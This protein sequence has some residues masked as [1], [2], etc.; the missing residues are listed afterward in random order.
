MSIFK[1]MILKETLHLL[2]DFRTL[3]V[4]LIM[5]LVLLLLF[6]F[7]IS[8]EVNDVRIVAVVGQ[9]NNHTR[10][11][12]ERLRTNPYFTFCGIVPYNQVEPAL[13]K[14]NADAAIIMTCRNGVNASQIIVDGSNTNIAQTATVYIESVL[15]GNYKSP[16]LTRTIYNPQLKSAY[17]FVPG[18]MGMIFILICA[19]MTSV[20]I[21]S[22]KESG[23]MNLLLVSPVRPR[24]IILGKMVPYFL[25]SCII[26]ALMLLLSYTVL[27]IPVSAA[28]VNVV[29]V[30]ILYIALALAFGLLIST[31]ADTQV[32]ALLVSGVLLMLPVIMLSGM[33][34]PIDN[35]PAILQWLSCIIPAR[36]YIEAMRTL[37]IQQLPVSYILT[38]VAVLTGMTAVVML[39]AIKKFNAK[40]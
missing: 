36:W 33:I 9:H 24:T 12:L 18:I 40:H 5:P 23:T 21:V 22:E 37:M 6:G 17:N 4:V 8:T 15:N 38:D 3:T 16:L 1:S 26:L 14:G 30:S 39:L 29:W 2:R 20:S 34:F 25:L 35:M 32:T 28:V 11:V 7:A 13:R 19:M 10:D 27:G 31:L